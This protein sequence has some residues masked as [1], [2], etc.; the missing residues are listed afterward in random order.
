MIRHDLKVVVDSATIRLREAG[1]PSPAHDAVALAAHL[2]AIEPAEVRRLM[3]L[4]W[5]DAPAGYDDLV[6]ERAHRIPLQHLTGVAPFR[7]LELAVGPG[8]F[9]PRPETEMLVD[10]AMN[11]L[12]TLP[13]RPILV[14]LC[15][16]SGAI[17]FGVKDEA[18]NVQ[19]YAVEVSP[20]ALSWAE[21]NQG[22]L[23]IDVTL[24][25][26]DARDA[27]AQLDG[28]VDV[29]T[30]NPPYIPPGRLPL[31]PE[32]RDHDPSL[33]LYGGGP[34]GLELPTAVAR[35]AARLLR[36][37]GVFVMEHADTQR[38]A[39]LALLADQGCWAPTADLDDLTGRPRVVVARRRGPSGSVDRTE[40][41]LLDVPDAG[42]SGVSDATGGAGR[43]P[44]DEVGEG[45]ELATVIPFRRRTRERKEDS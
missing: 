25:L 7:G 29:V 17:A 27:L 23:G 20:D 15:T 26:G 6:T 24:V 13:G 34:D 45:T 36:P 3:A 16:G 21:L 44:V 12:D 31:E 32:V 10:L 42:R 9:V 4:G 11:H 38:D 35:R 1:V 33:A 8:V 2:L 43:P 5:G 22:R 14:D 18:P 30:A 40:P 39:V 28:S 41:V 37:G 19:V